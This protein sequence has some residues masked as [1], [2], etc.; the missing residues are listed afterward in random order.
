VRRSSRPDAFVQLSL[1]DVP[2]AVSE[3]AWR[4]ELDGP[5]LSVHHPRCRLDPRHNAKTPCSWPA[6]PHDE[7]QRGQV[8]LPWD[9]QGCGKAGDLTPA[10]ICCL[11]GGIEISAYA[12]SINHG[13]CRPGLKG[14]C[15]IV[16]PAQRYMLA[17]RV[18]IR[19][20]KQ[21][22]QHQRGQIRMEWDYADGGKVGD[23]IPAYVCCACGRPEPNQYWL[24]LRHGCCDG[25]VLLP[26][27]DRPRKLY[28]FRFAEEADAD[29]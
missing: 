7:H 23:L 21:R 28:A 13:C 6:L 14:M 2:A 19:V 20:D 9:T 11:C 3:P 22:E 8:R 1:L 5:P 15:Q 10:W 16:K 27:Q 12:L 29:A 17:K 18:P 24:S 26:C 25:R 4:I